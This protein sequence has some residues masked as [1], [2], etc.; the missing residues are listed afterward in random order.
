MPVRVYAGVGVV[1]TMI[2]INIAQSNIVVTM[3]PSQLIAH[4]SE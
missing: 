3:L 4:F 2:R 1:N